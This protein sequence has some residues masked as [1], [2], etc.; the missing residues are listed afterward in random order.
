M[1]MGIL[2]VVLDQGT[3]LLAVKHLQ[4]EVH[5]F[6]WESGLSDLGTQPGAAFGILAHATPFLVL[7]TLGVLAIV[8]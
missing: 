8:G 6:T 1:V 3:K 7:L 5:W 4:P 2:L